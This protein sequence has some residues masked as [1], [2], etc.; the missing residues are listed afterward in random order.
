MRNE[1]RAAVVGIVVILAAACA[2]PAATPGATTP[3]TSPTSAATT[4]AATSPSPTQ[5]ACAAENLETIADGKLTI[6][7]D[8]PAYP[9]YF[10]GDPPGDGSWEISDPYS[11]EGFESATAYAIAEELGFA[12]EDVEWVV[13]RFTDSYKP[14]PKAFD[15]DI[16][17]VA[18]TP[19]RAE[20]V[21]LS[22]GYYFA[23]QAL[24]T[25]A[26]SP[27]A[28]ATTI[29]ELK[30]AKLGAQVGTTS[31]EFINEDI[32]PT[33]EVKVYD[34]NDQAV[35]ALQGGPAVLD[36][37]IVDLPTSDYIT[38]VQV[39]GAKTVGQFDIESARQEFSLVLEKDS[40]LTACVNEAIAALRADGT[41]DELVEE[42]LPF[43]ADTPVIQ[44]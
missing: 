30:D 13:V 11:G 6:G 16:N 19:E 10:G 3:A 24:V 20:T 5:D 34:T 36:G 42:W 33:A 7:T 26:D 2:A 40:P 4:G 35:A 25:L 41:L 44:P 14:G 37:I 22:E 12:E 31:L 38:N 29:A 17:Q 32:Q 1:S 18:S 15:F 28:N 21:D 27:F 23:N 9:P 43:Q 39:Q 8:N